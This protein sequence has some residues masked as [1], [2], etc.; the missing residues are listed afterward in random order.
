MDGVEATWPPER[1]DEAMARA[2]VLVVTA[3]KT[4]QSL[5]LIDARRLG[6]LPAGAF[7]IVVSRGGIV[8]EETL[9]EG[10]RSGRIAGAG[11]D[12]FATEP[13]PADS[14]LWDAPNL[15]ISPHCSAGSRQTRERV[16]AI[17][18]DIVRRFV[19]GQTLVNL[20][21]KRAGF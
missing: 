9:A 20:C 11:L 21:D 16:W 5:G 3:P 13:L 18:R 12:V 10:L 6:L 7:V 15:L 19:T 2:E 1:L 17:T 14:S 4:S 8:D